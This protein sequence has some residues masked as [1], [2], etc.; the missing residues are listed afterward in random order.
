MGGSHA[1]DGDL[2]V[3]GQKSPDD[4]AKVD[5]LQFSRGGG[6]AYVEG[7]PFGGSG[8]QWGSGDVGQG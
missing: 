3:I 4:G 5:F 1:V 2:L 6:F 7:K 8:E